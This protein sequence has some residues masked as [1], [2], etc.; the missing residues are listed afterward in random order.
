[1]TLVAQSLYLVYLAPAD[2]FLFP[3]LKPIL[4]G[5]NLSLLRRLKNI[6]WQSY[7]VFQK[8]HSGNASK[9]EDTLGAVYKE[10]RGVFRREQSPIAPK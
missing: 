8:R 4:K 2:F 5:D 3:K 6:C 9:L 1:M 7:A 10:W